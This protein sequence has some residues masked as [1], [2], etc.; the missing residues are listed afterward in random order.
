MCDVTARCAALVALA[1]AGCVPSLADNP[2]RDVR[3]ELPAQFSAMHQPGDAGLATRD[4]RDFF[5]SV[6]LQSLIEQALANNQELNVAL[7]EVVIAQA[8]VG[9]RRGEYLPRLGVGSVVGVEKVGE[10]TS[11]GVSDKAH[12]VPEHLGRFGFGL[13][14]SW[15]VDVWGRLRNA[16]QAAELRAQASVEHTHF[17]V[18]QLVAELARSYYELIALDAELEVL[19]R[20]IQLQKDALEVVRAE[21]QAAR[22]TE[23]AVQRFEAEV[24]K[25][26]SR[27]YELE[28]ERVQAE[29]R[30]NFLV[31]RYPQPVARDASQ[32]KAP[33]PALLETGV[34]S[35]LLENRPDV[36]QAELALKA[37]QLDVD[38]TRKRFYPALSIEAGGGYDSFNL[39]HLFL[40][41]QSLVYSL[42]GGLTAPLLNRAGIEADYRTANARQIQAIFDFERTLLQAYTDVINQLATFENLQRSYALRAQQVET[43]GRSVEA[44]SVL[45]QSA[46]ADYMEVLLTRRDSLDAELELLETKKQLLHALV[47]LYQALGGG[48][49][50][51]AS[52]TRSG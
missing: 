7:Q 43:L 45:F 24:L 36:R 37:A 14:A 41:P 25:N 28:K 27:L 23:L 15:E 29:N 8:E 31:G 1:L 11:Q 39:L 30:I 19:G 9:A 38:A 42:A 13:R 18:T 2:A 3:R 22:V 34:P 12:D 52:A 44:S 49:R 4:W 35:A 47:N 32:I 21:K 17:M 26:Q 5:P 6:E 33:L 20:N 46:R 51:P 40:T 48:W 16:A 10:E 50:R